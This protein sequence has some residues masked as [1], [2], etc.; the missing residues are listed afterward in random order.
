MSKKSKKEAQT[1]SSSDSSDDEEKSRIREAVLGVGQSAYYGNKSGSKAQSDAQKTNQGEDVK[2]NLKAFKHN[3]K[4][5]PDISTLK[6]NRPQDKNEDDQ[7]SLLNTT[8]EFR[9]YVAK[10]LAK[11][12][13]RDISE[14]ISES[15]WEKKLKRDKIQNGGVKLFSDSQGCFELKTQQAEREASLKA[16]PEPK[17]RKIRL[18]TSSSSDDSD[19]EDIKACVYS[20]ADIEQENLRLARLEEKSA[21]PNSS[22]NSMQKPKS[23]SEDV[24]HISLSEAKNIDIKSGIGKKKKKKKRKKKITTEVC[25]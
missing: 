21:Q 17:K 7:E 1:S 10:Q 5:C 23:D 11:L 25:L 20:V 14:C 22:T 4:I 6:S 18:S 13:D 12:L 2:P 24:L 8:P 9:A 3:G 19:N 15:V 16:T